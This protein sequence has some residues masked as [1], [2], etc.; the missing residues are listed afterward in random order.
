[1]TRDVVAQG[2]GKDQAGRWQVMGTRGYKAMRPNMMCRGFPYEVGETYEVPGPPR[3]CERGFHFCEQAANVWRYYD[4]SDSIVCE[5]EAL[6]EVVTDGTK[7][8]TDHIRI[9]RRLTPDEEGRL[10]YGHGYGDGDGNGNGCGY[11]D[12]RSYGYGCGDG[13]GHGYGYGSGGNDGY[14][15][16]YGHGSGYG[17]RYG[18]RYGHDNCESMGMSHYMVWED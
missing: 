9:V 7:S 16:G 15:N 6:G 2:K 13:C 17:N 3:L 8:V 12:G 1:M 10:R 18:D 11:G 5:V 14:G 4:R